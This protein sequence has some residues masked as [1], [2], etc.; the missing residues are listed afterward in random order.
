MAMAEHHETVK[1]MPGLSNR[2]QKRQDFRRGHAL[3]L[4]G[5]ARDV[6]VMRG[7]L[8]GETDGQR[9]CHTAGCGAIANLLEKRS[10][11]N[12]HGWMGLTVSVIPGS[13]RCFGR[14]VTPLFRVARGQSNPTRTRHGRG[15]IPPGRINLL[16]LEN[17]PCPMT[18]RNRRNGDG[19]FAFGLISQSAKVLFSW[20]WQTAKKPIC[21]TAVLGMQ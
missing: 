3:R 17:L 14:P 10:S 4:R 12:S 6:M 21:G 13:K 2:F 19:Y 20:S 5:A 7:S 8:H 11:T 15:F 9:G 16:M 1:L 18:R